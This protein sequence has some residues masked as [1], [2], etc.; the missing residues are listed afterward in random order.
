MAKEYL[1]SEQMAELKKRHPDANK[2]NF[3]ER[4]SKITVTKDTPWQLL[5]E[6][7]KHDIHCKLL[8]KEKL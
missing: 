8:L 5:N 1:N 2:T 4:I 6:F 7:D 3:M